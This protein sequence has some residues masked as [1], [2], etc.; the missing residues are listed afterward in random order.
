MPRLGS[1]RNSGQSTPGGVAISWDRIDIP[2]N[3]AVLMGGMAHSVRI[4]MPCLVPNK[5]TVKQMMD[6]M[7]QSG[8]LSTS[9]GCA[10]VEITRDPWAAAAK[11]GKSAKSKGSA[12]GPTTFGGGGILEDFMR[13]EAGDD[14]ETAPAEDEEGAPKATPAERKKAAQ[15][16]KEARAWKSVS[17]HLLK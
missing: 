15:A 7:Q 14:V 10:V 6:R 2:V 4:Q 16:K 11:R 12:Q 9:D 13:R 5:V 3:N 1:P 17:A 8:G